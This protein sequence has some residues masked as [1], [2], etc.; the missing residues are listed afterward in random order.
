M[1]RIPTGILHF[2]LSAFCHL[3]G[4]GVHGRELGCGQ[5]KL[6]GPGS[7]LHLYMGFRDQTQAVQLAPLGGEHLFLLSQLAGPFCV[8]YFETFLFQSLWLA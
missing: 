5:K 7:R 3:R 8:F 4:R 2:D 6:C 1:K